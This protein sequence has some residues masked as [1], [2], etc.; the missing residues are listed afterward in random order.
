MCG[1]KY[2]SLINNQ[3]YIFFNNNHIRLIVNVFSLHSTDNHCFS[4]VHLYKKC[5]NDIN[6]L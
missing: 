1:N 4:F 3:M 6:P 2:I 5:T